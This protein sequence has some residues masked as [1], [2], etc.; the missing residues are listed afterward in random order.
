MVTNFK[1]SLYIFLN[2]PDIVKEYFNEKRDFFVK[3]AD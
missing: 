2:D 3:D 1:S